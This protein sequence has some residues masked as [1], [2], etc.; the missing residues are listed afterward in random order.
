MSL[1]AEFSLRS[2]DLVL[3][4]A[5]EAAPDVTVELDT[6]MAAGVDPPTFVFW[7]VGGDVEALEAG[8]DRD[9]TVRS[10]TCVERRDGR[11]LYRS[12][13]DGDEALSVY[14]VYQRLGAAPMAATGTADGWRRRVRF[15]D[16][17]SVV[18]M[19]EFCADRD[20]TFRL[21]R[22]YTPG[23]SEVVD[24]FGLSAEQ[25]RALVAAERAG[26]FDV[27]RGTSLDE[28]GDELGV[29]GQSASER[30]RRGVS[31]LVTHTLLSDF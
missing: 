18:E 2:P 14:P 10:A 15:P 24:E 22:L 25:R 1:I 4:A 8:L 23:D 26:Y 20:V 5:L 19:R 11:R 6:Q 27:P 9:P 30:L 31:E 7:A 13:L 17:D 12:R 29:S 21:H 3:S 16:R 28:L